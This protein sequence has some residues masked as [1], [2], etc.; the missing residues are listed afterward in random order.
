M[1]TQA[2][3]GWSFKAWPLKVKSSIAG[4]ELGHKSFS[5]I[6]WLGIWP[7]LWNVPRKKKKEE[8]TLSHSSDTVLPFSQVRFGSV[9]R[10]KSRVAL[11]L[12]KPSAPL[13]ARGLLH[14]SGRVEPLSVR[15]S[16]ARCQSTTWV[17]SNVIGNEWPARLPQT[18]PGTSKRISLA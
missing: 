10:S 6:R 16:E 15:T 9:K 18:G 2:A 17:L 4:G 3:M 8:K 5:K 13:I 14:L 1:F 7:P 11:A 12:I